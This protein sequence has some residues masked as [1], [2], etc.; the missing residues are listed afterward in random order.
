MSNGIKDKHSPIWRYAYITKMEWGY[1]SC[2]RHKYHTFFFHIHMC[3]H[4]TQ[5]DITN[6]VCTPVLQNLSTNLIKYIIFDIVQ[7]LSDAFIVV[8][9]K[10]YLCSWYLLSYTSKIWGTELLMKNQNVFNYICFVK[11]GTIWLLYVTI[12]LS[13]VRFFH[14]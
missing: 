12:N 5:T 7:L 11:F 4:T 6:C 1:K 2:N 10:S 9:I 8:D 3:D 14:E 13:A